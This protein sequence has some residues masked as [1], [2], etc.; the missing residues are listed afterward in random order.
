MPAHDG[1]EV[2]LLG[3]GEPDGA[4]PD[5]TLAYLERIFL[6]NARLDGEL[7]AEDRRRRCRELAERRA[8]GLQ[9]DYERIG[10][11]PLLAQ[12]RAQARALEA[13]LARR[14]SGLTVRIAMQF[15]DPSIDAAVGEAVAGGVRRIIALPLYPLCGASTTIAALDALQ[16]ALERR[17]AKWIEVVAVTCR[18]A[19]PG[20]G[21]PGDDHNE[22]AQSGSARGNS[23]PRTIHYVSALRNPVK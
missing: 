4:S 22:H 1:T 12:C 8:P 13:E 3:F 11:S 6:A 15:T 16:E 17:G 18:H 19:H 9:A 7:T 20:F 23:Q 2:I 14:G 21:R 10:G 5:E